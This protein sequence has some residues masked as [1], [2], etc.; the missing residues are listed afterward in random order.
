MDELNKEHNELENE[1]DKSNGSEPEKD[2][3][4]ESAF[5]KSEE[6][7][8][9]EADTDEAS[10]EDRREAAPGEV[11]FMD[12]EE[13]AAV[14]A[15]K[16]TTIVLVSIIVVLVAV[17]ALLGTLFYMKLKEKKSDDPV[18]DNP[19]VTE[20]PVSTG[21]AEVT[22]VP[23]EEVVNPGEQEYD[24][25]VELGQYKGIEADYEYT[26]ITEEDIEDRIRDFC[27][28]NAEEVEVTD[29]PVEEGD[30]V[31]ID[32]T[33]YM[34]GEAFEGGTGTDYELEIGSGSFIPGFEEGLIG[35]N[36][37]DT[38]EL[39][40]AFPDPY[41]NNPDLA[42]QPVK[43]VVTIKSIK[44]T[45]IPEMTNELV[46]EYTE[47]SSVVEYIT[48]T[49][50]ELEEYAKEEADEALKAAISE[51]VIANATF[52]GD[53]DKEISDTVA[54]WK[55]YYD[56]MYQ[57]YYGADAATIFGYYY[58]WSAEEYDEYMV[59]QYTFQVKYSYV[60]KKIAETENFDVTEDEF[61]ERFQEY[62]FDYY[63]F[64]SKEEVYAEISP[65]EVD[66]LIKA[67]ILQDKA[68][69]LMLDSA[70]VNNK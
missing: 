3:Y 59:E 5:K 29:R 26:P 8:G 66:E 36:L 64:E 49:R 52:G 33:G 46:Q 43:F 57:S 15:S 23:T 55:N 50:D 44:S 28:E 17:I 42:G 24:V 38:V 4:L 67:S 34:N 39:D 2:S 63:G 21:E 7:F 68:E 11:N 69:K 20:A 31:L 14:K 65:E 60:L 51:Q 70:V 22:A 12:A 32:F 45:V 18:P 1:F 10:A 16:R 47:Y 54:Y 25:T 40:I 6:L 37:D 48:A 35:A 41:P 56:S 13:A 27:E 9:S 58:G 19:K 30:V 62:F 61:E 53:I